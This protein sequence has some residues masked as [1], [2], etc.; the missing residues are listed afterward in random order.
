MAKRKFVNVIFSHHESSCWGEGLCLF[1]PSPPL[2]E[3]FINRHHRYFP[4]HKINGAF[5]SGG[6]KGSSDEREREN[7]LAGMGFDR[8]E[9]LLK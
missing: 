3:K 8:A 5:M 7:H 9:K 1:F 4:I 2:L 6:N